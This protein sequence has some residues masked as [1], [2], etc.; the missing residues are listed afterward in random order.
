MHSWPP[1]FVYKRTTLPDTKNGEPSAEPKPKS[2]LR[3]YGSLSGDH[4]VG[5]RRARLLEA[6]LDVLAREGARGVS[7]RK[8]I[9]AAEL[10]PRYFKESFVDVDD[11]L[12]SIFDWQFRELLGEL[13]ERRSDLYKDPVDRIRFNV[14]TSIDFFLSDHR[15]T[16][17]LM[18]LE[19]SG[20]PSAGLHRAKAFERVSE[21]IFKDSVEMSLDDLAYKNL[22]GAAASILVSGTVYGLVQ[23][24][25]GEIV[26]TPEQYKD[27][28]A[29][30]LIRLA[31]L[32]AR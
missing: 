17:V 8:V 32:E 21:L 30:M 7:L 10:N 18:A 16:S 13:E 11:L 29:A 12:S 20:A 24:L 27:L 23:M 26:V 3:S 14:E 6:G 1:W 15:R 2:T 31:G 4:R 22:V 9:A 19:E 25:R 5:E 28:V